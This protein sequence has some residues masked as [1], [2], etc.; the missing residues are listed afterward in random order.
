MNTI[1]VENCKTLL[2]GRRGENEVT[3]VAFDFTEWQTEFGSGVVDLY[4]KRFGD[5]SAYP[6]VLTIDGTVA[7]WLVTETDTNVAGYGKAEYVY[8]V[9]EK[10]AKSAVFLFF[11]A[12]DIGQPASEPPDP[13]ESWL[14]QLT[15]LGA[16]TEA[17]AQEAAQS[18]SDAAE[19]AASIEGDVQQ[20]EEAARLALAAQSA[21][22]DAQAAAEQAAQD[23]HVEYEQ[24]AGQVTAQGQAIA[25]NS[26][27]IAD[28]DTELADQKSAI[29][30][31]TDLVDRKAGALIDTASGSI[32]S[33]VPDS[34]I[35]NLLGVTVDIE[36]V[37]DLHGYDSPWPAGGGKNLL[38][39][40]TNSTYVSVDS[41]GTITVNGTVS[42]T[43]T[44]NIPVNLPTGTYTLSANNPVADSSIRL[45][46]LNGNGSYDVSVYLSAVNVVATT[47][48][49]EDVSRFWITL[50]AKTYNNLKMKLQ[51]ESGSTATA[52]SPY[53]NLCPISG[54]DSVEVSNTSTNIWDEEW[55]VGGY[56]SANGQPW[57]TTDRIRSKADN[58]ISV[59]P[60]TAYYFK[61]PQNT[62][63]C[64]YDANKVYIGTRTYINE[65]FTTPANAYYMRFACQP[66]YGTTYNH[67]ISINY[68]ATDHAYHPYA[69]NTYTIT[70]GQTVYGGTLTIAEDGSVKALVD[71]AM[72]DLGT[73]TWTK[74]ESSLIGLPC[75]YAYINGSKRGAPYF[76]CSEYAIK[77]QRTAINA[78]SQIA[79]GNNSD[80]TYCVVRDDRYAGSTAADF[81]TAMPGVQLVY[82]LATPVTI[83]LDPVTISTISGQQNNVWADG[84]AV[85]VEYA[86]DLKHYIDSKIA[87]AVAAMS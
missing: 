45:R 70:L 40:P 31:L 1:N 87:A 85:S 50:R 21:A 53:S 24:L 17:H 9:D 74:N 83:Q 23:A 27:D 59:L 68:P 36:P 55:E 28:L 51:V 15:A 64:F 3:T 63:V 13:Y 65:A 69:G 19:S 20:A 11:V 5:D 66:I 76:N 72:V 6:V 26:E 29:E 80:S 33:F 8:R 30:D 10:I 73:L 14:E 82:P 25:Q 62:N 41:D 18:A 77:R 47:T 2:I 52:W 48:L 60:N 71:R 67:D 35:D 46:Y 84:G 56:A 49:T 32:A 34:T 86:A 78:T 81:K 58:Y 7:S 12:E 4:V 57:N 75:F 43:T 44:I 38:P 54:W 42:S 16:E 22:E 39:L 79:P 61:T 37:Q